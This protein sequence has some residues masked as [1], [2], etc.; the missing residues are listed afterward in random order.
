[1]R[2][3]NAPNYLKNKVGSGGIPQNL[4]DDAEKHIATAYDEFEDYVRDQ[5]ENLRLSCLAISSKKALGK[6][7]QFALVTPIV[8]LK[9]HGTMFGYALISD[10]SCIVVDFLERIDFFDEDAGIIIDVYQQ[11]AL[12]IIDRKLQAG[13]GR[14]GLDFSMELTKACE[15]YYKKHSC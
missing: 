10:M 12:V 4:I 7:E 8:M 1:M 5:L 15:R 13:G 6:E 11:S 14:I 9:A 2:I 3:F